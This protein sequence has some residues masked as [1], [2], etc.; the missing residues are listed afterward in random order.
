MATLS[1]VQANYGVFGD[2]TPISLAGTNKRRIGRTQQRVS[3]AGADI[4]YRVEMTATAAG[5]VATLNGT[6]GAVTQDTGTPS[7]A[8]WTGETGDLAAKDFEG[9]DIPAM[10]TGYVYGILVEVGAG[11]D[12]YIA[13]ASSAAFAP[14][15]PEIQPGFTTLFLAPTGGFTGTPANLEFTWESHAGAIGDTVTVTYCAKSS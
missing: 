6:T 2:A 14:D 9:V 3:Y 11:N 12:R 13:L 5:D 4:L 15:I 1:D 8:R 7:V 10:S